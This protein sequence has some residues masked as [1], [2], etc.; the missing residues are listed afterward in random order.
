MALGIRLGLNLREPHTC[1][2]AAM[3]DTSGLHSFE[4]T[5][6]PGRTDVQHHALNDVI[7]RAFSS[8]GIPVTKEPVGLTRRGGKGL[9]VSLWCVGKPLTWEET[10]IS[11][12][13]DSYVD[14]AAREAGAPAEHA[15]IR[16]I[17]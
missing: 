6:A 2:C 17:S 7:H 3:V 13:A 12:L 10:A 16:E 4:C 11:T 9:A 5:S 8:A 14:S 15:A 1:R